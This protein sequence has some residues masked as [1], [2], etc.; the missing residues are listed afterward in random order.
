[1]SGGYEKSL[2][3]CGVQGL[4][5]LYC[6][7]AVWGAEAHGIVM[8]GALLLVHSQVQSYCYGYC[9]TYHWVVTHAKEAHHLY[10]GRY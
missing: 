2:Q 1:M 9:C 4:C 3:L 7:L 5:M 10:V 6:V 8:P